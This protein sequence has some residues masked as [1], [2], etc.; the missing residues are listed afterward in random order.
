MTWPERDRGPLQSLRD[1]GR[2]K[3]GYW[4]V[5]VRAK[6]T[7]VTHEDDDG[8]FYWSRHITLGDDAVLDLAAL[9]LEGWSIA[10]RPRAHG[11]TIRIS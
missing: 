6:Y 2:L 11:L 10:I 4:P 5:W 7:W 9:R 8:P 1:L 3:D